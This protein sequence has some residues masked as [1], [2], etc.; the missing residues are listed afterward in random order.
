LWLASIQG[1]LKPALCSKNQSTFDSLIEEVHREYRESNKKS[2]INFI[3]AS[4]SSD[5]E[6]PY[7]ITELSP[8]ANPPTGWR[9][10]YIIHRNMLNKRLQLFSPA[11]M[12]MLNIWELHGRQ[13]HLIDF[14]TFAP[15]SAAELKGVP[16]VDAALLSTS[17]LETSIFHVE[18]FDRALTKHLDQGRNALID[19][20]YTRL[21]RIYY[22]TYIQPS[23]TCRP[24]TKKL[25]LHF[26]T[27]NLVSLAQ[28]VMAN[29][30]LSSLKSNIQAFSELFNVEFGAEEIKPIDPFF[31]EKDVIEEWKLRSKRLLG[32]DHANSKEETKVEEQ[33][34]PVPSNDTAPLLDANVE[35]PQVNEPTQKPENDLK[36]SPPH[37]QNLDSEQGE[38]LK[39]FKRV[40]LP[41]RFSVNFKFDD[42][43]KILEPHPSMDSICKCLYNV[44]ESLPNG[45]SNIPK[46]FSILFEASSPSNEFKL[47]LLEKTGIEIGQL[48][49]YIELVQS[50][51]AQ[52]RP[53]PS[54]GSRNG[55]GSQRIMS[56][57]LDVQMDALPVMTIPV[58]STLIEDSK[59]T[60]E[61]FCKAMEEVVKTYSQQYDCYLAV[62]YGEHANALLEAA[63]DPNAKFDHIV[64]VNYLTRLSDA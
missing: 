7:P 50:T 15:L 41:F 1:R 64:K 62:F 33:K 53:L 39:S 34:T 30:L 21:L 5:H 23:V 6:E 54:I 10:R 38:S 47:D 8:L 48:S 26:P 9:N 17:A 14:Q 60:I 52:T 49:K 19:Q 55:I 24:R 37:D 32:Q 22:D 31:P 20:W 42:T 3:L 28:H 36:Q 58:P 16:N 29:E 43:K 59:K 61:K 56:R 45:I 63:A 12:Q 57:R 2:I 40:N 46:F 25:V 27:P 11:I 18:T 35:I 51:N 13:V 44:L 4:S